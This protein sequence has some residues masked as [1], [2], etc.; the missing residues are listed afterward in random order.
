MESGPKK[1]IFE[2]IID[3]K[4]DELKAILSN[5]ANMKEIA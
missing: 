4:D 2:A 1:G 5:K 3:G